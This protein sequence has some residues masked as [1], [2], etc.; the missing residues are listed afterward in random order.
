[1]TKQTDRQMCDH[2]LT[3]QIDVPFVSSIIAE[4][5]SWGSLC[6]MKQV[7]YTAGHAYSFWFLVGTT[8]KPC[9]KRK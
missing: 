2:R 5:P 9:R 7:V 8:F 6:D 4:L 3:L 1:M